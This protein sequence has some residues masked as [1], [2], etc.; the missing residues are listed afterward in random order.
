MKRALKLFAD[1]AAVLVVLPFVGLYQVSRLLLGPGRAFP[2]Y[3][4]ALAL[5]PGLTG[6][7]VRRAFY[8]L[9]LARC[10]RDVYLS[11]GTI[12]S[13]PGTWLG[14]RIYVGAYCT[15]GRVV[16]EDD[17]L[18]AS[19]VSVLNG[20]RQ[21]GIDRMD[22]PIREQPGDWPVV[23][24]GSNSWVGERAVVMADVGRQSVVGAGSVVVKPVPGRAV[25]VGVPA[26]VLRFRGEEAMA[27]AAS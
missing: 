1:L 2:G 26:R 21:H 6:V 8:R 16:V 12:L 24:I 23:H 19:H 7:I 5:W 11:F 17:V 14:D 18:I 9:V 3:S 13:D 4:Q 10:G 20:A 15:L 27:S 25:V 22:E